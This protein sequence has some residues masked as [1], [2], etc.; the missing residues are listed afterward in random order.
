MKFIIISFLLLVFSPSIS[1]IQIDSEKTNSLNLSEIA[2]SVTPIPLDKKVGGIQDIFVADNYIFLAGISSVI[3]CTT[4]GKIIRQIITDGAVND[5]SGDVQQ[6]RIFVTVGSSIECYDFSGKLMKKYPLKHNG[7]C[8]YLFNNTLWVCSFNS[9]ASDVQHHFSYFDLQTEKEIFIPFDIHEKL[10]KTRFTL[11]GGQFT[12][13]GNKLYYS[14][15][16]RN[17][18]YTV[19]KDNITPSTQWE[20]TPEIPVDEQFCFSCK[21]GHLGKY[22]LINYSKK[23]TKSMFFR[24]YTY[25]KDTKTNKTHQVITDREYGLYLNGIRDDVFNSG[26][27]YIDRGLNNEGYFCYIKER[28]EIKGDKVGDIPVKN[29]PVIFIVKVKN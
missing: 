29:G 10:D 7:C 19:T 2:E 14:T 25:L 28:S 20:I 21:S 22:T 3:Q 4:S 12:S 6:K 5:I 27:L 15:P 17:I 11:D 18:I 16:Y 26:Y 9:T 1:T 8:S 24:F 23:D 13:Y